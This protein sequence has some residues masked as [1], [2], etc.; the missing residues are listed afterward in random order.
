[1]RRQ[2]ECVVPRHWSFLAR[3]PPDTVLHHEHDHEEYC[4]PDEHD[5]PSPEA[6]RLR[7]SRT[8]TLYVED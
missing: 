6:K 1:M 7:L 2:H 4:Q 3:T 8:S 5:R